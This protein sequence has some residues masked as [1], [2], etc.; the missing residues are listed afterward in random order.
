LQLGG[1]AV[2]RRR[3]GQRLAFLEVAK[4]AERVKELEDLVENLTV[5]KDLA[6]ESCEDLKA[7]MES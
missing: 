2:Q 5:D 3:A 4:M 1:A 7:D 6:E